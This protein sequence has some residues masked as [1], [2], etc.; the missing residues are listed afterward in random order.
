MT[1]RIPAEIFPPGEFIREEL[2][3]RGWDQSDLAEILGSYPR[4]VSEIVTGKRAITPE[5]AKK[6]AAA[7]GTTPE[8][9]MNLEGSYRLWHGE[10]NRV[11]DEAVM[12]RASLYEKVP[13]RE[14][15]RRGWIER[16]GN[17]NVL[18]S[19][20][21]AF[22]EIGSLEEEPR[23][24]PVAAKSTI[25]LNLW[26]GAWLARARQL[27][28]G[29]AASRFTDAKLAAAIGRLKT[30]LHAPQEVRHVPRILAEAG[31]RFVVVEHLPR[32]KIDGACFWL[33]P[34]SPVIAMSL[35][36]DRID[37]FW[38]VLMHEIGHVENR[39]G[40]KEYEPF[41]VD[42]C[43]ENDD[44][45]RQVAA[46]ERLVNAFAAEQ[47][48]PQVALKDFLARVQPLYSKQRI[49]GFAALM[50]V[51]PGIVVG[52]IHHHVKDYRLGRDMLAKIREPLTNS[53]LTDGWGRT[54]TLVSA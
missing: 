19:R 24:W 9:W 23:F 26:H 17:L 15:A 40:L 22:Y 16:S 46:E 51:H 21:L 8:L 53:A 32:T 11:H 37:N 27:A 50:K 33:S 14:L 18:E 12:R 20:I 39:H 10:K 6:L 13:V 36:F 35:R 30:L 41:D 48:I 28:R 52:Q 45:E 38:H 4:M 42:L 5:T 43:A 44:S 31:V 7:F 3:T 47:L 29:V 1:Q 54:V 2:A 49:R 25:P 34:S